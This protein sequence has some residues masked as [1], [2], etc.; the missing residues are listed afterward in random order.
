MLFLTVLTYKS[1][2]CDDHLLGN[3]AKQHH[4]HDNYHKL[5]TDH[6]PAY[7]P[8]S[9]EKGF[10]NSCQGT[11]NCWPKHTASAVKRAA[12]DTPCKTQF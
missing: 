10:P 7:L 3:H 5:P 2:P 6:S 9:D 4:H 1:Y 8:Q 11:G 12:G